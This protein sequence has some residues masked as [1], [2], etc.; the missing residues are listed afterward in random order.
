MDFEFAPRWPTF[1]NHRK[2]NRFLMIFKFWLIGFW[3]R[4]FQV[5][6]LKMVSK[7]ISK[8]TQNDVKN[9]VGNRV[10]VKGRMRNRFPGFSTAL[11]RL[12]RPQWEGKKGRVLS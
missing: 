1:K 3:E 10:G 6:V 9:D 11:S 4:F 12:L 7:S 5:C 2:T 8:C